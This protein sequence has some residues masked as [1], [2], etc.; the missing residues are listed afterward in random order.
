M[1]K[2]IKFKSI[3]TLDI[4]TTDKEFIKHLLG[5]LVYYKCVC[6]EDFHIEFSSQKGVHIT[7]FCKK[8]KC[9]LCRFVFDDFRRF[10]YDQYRKKHEKNVLFDKKEVLEI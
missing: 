2:K 1:F 9:D 7:L 5:K 8:R 6:L 4:D 3:N 10:A